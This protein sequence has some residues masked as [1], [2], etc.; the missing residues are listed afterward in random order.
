M[1]V[2][3]IFLLLF[4]FTTFNLFCQIDQENVFVESDTSKV[5]KT[6]EKNKRN[7]FLTIFEGNPG[8]AALYSLV[9]PGAGQAY[10]KKWLKIPLAL[11]IDGAAGYWVYFTRKEY[12]YYDDIY[13]SLLAGGVNP[14]FK[15]P[16]DVEPFR[17]AWLQRK[18]Y[19][20]VYMSIAHL[21]T[22]LDAYVDRHLIEFD[23]SEDL[24]HHNYQQ[25]GAYP[26]IGITIPIGQ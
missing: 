11:A 17:S 22:V 15:S 6:T 25:S 10:N 21:V 9:I 19:A 1:N 18:E 2:R 5:G 26:I 24:T 3:F 20:W 8:R 12:N 13:R 4:S 16:R 23:I 14:Q 7:T